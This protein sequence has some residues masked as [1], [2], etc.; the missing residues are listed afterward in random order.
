MGN[1]LV[2]Y[3][4]LFSAGIEDFEKYCNTDIVIKR[5][6]FPNTKYLITKI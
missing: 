3:K 4:K 5:Q 2:Y 6:Y 1:I